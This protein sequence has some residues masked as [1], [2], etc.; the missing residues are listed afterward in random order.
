MKRKIKD[1]NE[2]EVSILNKLADTIIEKELAKLKIDKG[3]V[4]TKKVWKKALIA[5]LKIDK[6]TVVTLANEKAKKAEE[7]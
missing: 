6:G 3:T 7:A 2:H 5:I 1:L 4:A